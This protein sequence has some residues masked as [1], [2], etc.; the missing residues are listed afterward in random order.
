MKTI[1]W[2]TLLIISAVLISACK[3]DQNKVDAPAQT[4]N[5]ELITTFIISFYDSAGTQLITKAQF[6]D[7]DG[8]GGNTPTVFD[9][10]RLNK[11][12]IFN[13]S[14]ILLNESVTPTDTISNEVKEESADHIFCFTLSNVNIDI[15]RTDTDGTYEL[16][17]KSK[18][19]T[20]SVSNGSV[21]IKLKHQ[22]ESKNGT[23]IPGETDIELD[24]VTI[25][26]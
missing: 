8:E 7:I 23:C 15:V 14:I 26:E 22:P 25:I 20:G 17:L 5:E 12:S 13:A 21:K 19:T 1:R 18:W 24:F 16:G 2:I 3:K 9:S 4:N 10:I 11:N 6:K